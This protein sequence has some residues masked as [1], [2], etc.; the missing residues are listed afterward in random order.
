MSVFGDS[1]AVDDAVRKARGYMAPVLD[2]RGNGGGALRALRGLVRG[3][4][5]HE[6]LIAVEHRRSGEE[7]E[8]A[9]P[10][11]SPF[12]GTLVVLVD[13]RSASAAEMF[14]RIVQ[15]EKRGRV[16]GDRTGAP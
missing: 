5:D 3:A 6:V 9:R 4:F 7:R 2:L 10:A 13:S 8:V 16:I 12:A 1:S 14:A 11:R 15:I